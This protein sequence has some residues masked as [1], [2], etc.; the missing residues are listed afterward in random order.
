M[1]NEQTVAIR[2]E[3]FM[4]LALCQFVSVAIHGVVAK[5]LDD[6]VELFNERDIT[7]LETTFIE[8]SN[9]TQNVVH[10]LCTTC[11]G[12]LRIHHPSNEIEDDGLLSEFKSKVVL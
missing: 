5:H 4:P 8:K 6:V 3:K 2:S 12:I 1:L 10:T 7:T 11:D 9:N